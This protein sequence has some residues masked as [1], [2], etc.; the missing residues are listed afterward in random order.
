MGIYG[1]NNK[2]NLRLCSSKTKTSDHYLVKHFHH[3][4]HLTISISYDLTK[5]II[6]KLNPLTTCIFQS[7]KKIIDKRFYVIK[8]PLK[9]MKLSD[10]KKKFFK[11]SLKTH[12]LNVHYLT[13]GTTEKIINTIKNQGDLTQL[14][15][16]EDEFK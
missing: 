14:Q 7:E 11:G 10:C 3:Y 9:R 12:L 5:A 2:H 8:C 4:H 1:L 6:N 16:N 13:L 15:V